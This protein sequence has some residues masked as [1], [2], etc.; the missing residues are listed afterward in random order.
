LHFVA[1]NDF[2]NYYYRGAIDVSQKEEKM[3]KFFLFIGLFFFSA[4]CLAYQE[5]NVF[6]WSGYLPSE[7]IQQFTKETGIKVNLSEYDTN[8]TMYVKLKTSP[9]VG[10]DVI[11]PS[12]YLIDRMRK[13]NMLYK[14]DKSLI[15]N[16]QYINPTLLNK[17]FDPHNEYSIPYL[18]GVTGI[19][20]NSNY[21]NPKEIT[22][23]KD[24]W[25]PKYE[26]QLMM[27]SD[28]R[29]VFSM[30]LLT[31][32]Y[33]AN[34]TNPEQIKN[35]YLLLK[36][37][38]PNV[39]IFNSDVE[40]TVYIDEDAII[41]MGWNGDISISQG[42]NPALKF[43]FPKEGFVI[44]IDCLA[45][46]G[47]SLHPENAHK[48]VNF[49]LR[50]DIAAKIALATKYASPNLEAIKML[51]KTVQENPVINP[52]ASILARGQFQTDVGSAISIYE[53]YWELLKLEQ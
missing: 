13:Q 42:E 9:K 35:A 22:S 39:K 3:K 47:N 53:K 1:Y 49:L 43:I 38:L 21:L 17:P 19:V 15:P 40:Q 20:V 37:L 31:L 4:L 12:T 27:L 11:I 45:I 34:T 25:N 46:T 51:P 24:L 2:I 23:W 44:W 30:S 5:V 50:P 29:E 36:K 41:G 18:W 52:P 14:L 10:Y 7:V 26:N 33:P 16:L 32:G 48:F 28:F 6:S 8:E